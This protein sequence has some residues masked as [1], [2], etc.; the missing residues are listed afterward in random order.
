M[1]REIESYNYKG[2]LVKIF[3]HHKEN[4]Y[5]AIATDLAQGSNDK[6]TGIAFF[7]NGIFT[8]SEAKNFARSTVEGFV[9]F[10]HSTVD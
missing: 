5:E 6:A 3:V 7:N 10:A 8:R 4:K 9:Y 1:K 2:Y